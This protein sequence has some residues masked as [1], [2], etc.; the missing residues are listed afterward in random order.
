MH[1]G[2]LL[3]LA[4]VIV[5]II[6]LFLKALT[7]A[8]EGLLPALHQADPSFPDGFPTIWGGLATWAQIVLVILIVV[9][10]ALA[11]LGVRSAAM[12]RS[13][14]LVTAVIGVALLAYAI[15]KYLDAL[16]S[17]DAIQAGMAKA[18]AGGMIPEAYT[19]SAGIGFFILIIGTV[20]MIA[21]GLSG[22]RSSES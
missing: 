5:G 4:G 12:S 18:A 3:A 19:V 1:T 21:G 20:L 14:S 2:R 11:L 8:G 10:V 16:D 7:S 13:S 22:L 9:V 6:G 17:A 15:I